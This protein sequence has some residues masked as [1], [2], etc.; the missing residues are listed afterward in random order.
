M[1]AA[2]KGYYH[3]M[4]ST[5]AIVVVLLLCSGV[6]HSLILKK[7]HI[8]VEGYGSALLKQEI[9]HIVSAQ[10]PI[11]SRY[12]LYEI[13]KN[14]LPYIQEIV[15]QQYKP[16]ACYISL[17]PYEPRCLINNEKVFLE[18]GVIVEKDFFE[19]HITNQL[20]CVEVCNASDYEQSLFVD[21]L[22][23][24]D[25]EILKNFRICWVDKTTIRLQPHH[26]SETTFIV[27]H[28]MQLS[29]V[30]QEKIMRIIQQEKLDNK[31][32]HLVVDLRFQNQVICYEKRELYETH[33]PL[34]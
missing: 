27:H 4:Q 16:Q 34:A 32:V 13:L 22:K 33:Y 3:I 5:L 7:V 28:T 18:N 19:P 8:G 23:N 30:V 2:K 11:S 31:Y 1:H 12:A 20:S 10:L 9:E 15:L 6:A 29:E 17:K 24:I 25:T 26:L 14:K 21:W